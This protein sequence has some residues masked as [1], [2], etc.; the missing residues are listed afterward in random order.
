MTLG[1]NVAFICQN[2]R[3]FYVCIMNVHVHMYVVS[4]YTI[5]VNVL[6]VASRRLVACTMMSCESIPFDYNP[7]W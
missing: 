4:V 2:E 3:M 7:H 6:L 5:H 1:M